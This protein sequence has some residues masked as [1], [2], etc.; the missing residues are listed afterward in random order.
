MTLAFEW[1]DA[2][3]RSNNLKH[4]VTFETAREAFLDP[5]HFSLGHQQAGSEDRFSMVGLS[6]E[7]GL[8]V[9]YTMRGRKIR[10][11]SAREATSH[12]YKRYW[13][14]RLLHPRGSRAAYR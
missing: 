1:D 9:I 2:K 13:T 3:A 10:L 14:N 5:H 11:I 6:N 4:G 7:K 12:E 8:V